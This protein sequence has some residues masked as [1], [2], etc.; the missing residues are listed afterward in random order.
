MTRN[1]MT[2]LGFLALSSLGDGQFALTDKNLRADNRHCAQCGGEVPPGRPGRRC[3]VC[4]GLQLSD[5]ERAAQ[6]VPA[7]E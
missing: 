1:R 6:N 5:A 4:R 3:K 7:K 2:L